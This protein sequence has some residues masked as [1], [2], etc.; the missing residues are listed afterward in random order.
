[1]TTPFPSAV[2]LVNI[3]G[4]AYA[5]DTTPRTGRVTFELQQSLADS[6]DKVS[7]PPCVVPAIVGVTNMVIAGGVAA[8]GTGGIGTACYSVVLIATDYGNISGSNTPW[9]YRV[10]WDLDGSDPYIAN[11]LFPH[12][13]TPVDIS[14]LEPYT[15]GFG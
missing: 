9:Y 13:A 5:A 4:S 10:T 2:P 1:M 3:T 15:G 14:T 8:P 12:S 6:A 11:Y 7:I